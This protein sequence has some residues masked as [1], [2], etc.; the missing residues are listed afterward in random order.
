M[1]YS[2]LI[3]EKSIGLVAPD[4]TKSVSGVNSNTLKKLI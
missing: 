3:Y 2:L 4:C 1:S